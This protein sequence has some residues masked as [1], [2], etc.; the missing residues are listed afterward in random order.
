MLSEK[1]EEQ[2]KLKIGTYPYTYVRVSAMKSKLIQKGEYQKILKMSVNEIISYL[3]STEYKDAIDELAI[4]YEGI[5]L[6]ELALNLDMANK[7]S[8]L[9]QISPDALHDIIEAYAARWSL[10]NIKTILRGKFSEASTDYIK[11]LLIPAGIM[12]RGYNDGLLKSENVVQVIQKLHFLEKKEIDN[13]ITEF[14]KDHNLYAVENLLNRKYYS[15]FLQ[16]S[17]RIP[18]QGATFRTFIQD[19]I[20]IINIKTL[21]RMKREGVQADKIMPVMLLPGNVLNK[22]QLRKLASVKDV[23]ELIGKLKGT[24]FGGFFEQELQDSLID[25]EIELDK[26]LYEKSFTRPHRTPLSLLSIISYMFAKEL[27]V[28][29]LQGIIKAK[30]LGLAD[31]IIEKKIVVM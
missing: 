19:E 11:S 26:Y 1:L 23:K 3:Q 31:D 9:I 27:E 15:Q 24:Q 29:N 10:Y 22:G 30:Q 12:K 5:D 21:L 16:F 18:A 6:I 7:I 4:K 28:K 8:K 13:L 2:G 14:N 17:E 25:I 20:D